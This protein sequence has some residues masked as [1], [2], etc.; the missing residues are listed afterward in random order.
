MLSLKCPD[1][2]AHVAQPSVRICMSYNPKPIEGTNKDGMGVTQ[3][4][5]G[6]LKGKLFGTK[7]SPL[8]GS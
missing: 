8:A 1:E 2:Q 7:T 6:S 3:R 4:K 5:S